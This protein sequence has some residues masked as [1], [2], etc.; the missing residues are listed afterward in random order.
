MKRLAPSVIVAA[1]VFCA[2]CTGSADDRADPSPAQTAP[3]TD[4]P[5]PTSAPTT[6]ATEV[7]PPADSDPEITT[8]DGEAAALRQPSARAEWGN[9]PF[10]V[11]AVVDDLPEVLPPPDASQT[12]FGGSDQYSVVAVDWKA[13]FSA[14]DRMWPPVIESGSAERRDELVGDLFCTVQNCGN[15]EPGG[16]GLSI[17][18]PFGLSSNGRATEFEKEFGFAIENIEAVAEASRDRTTI[19]LASGVDLGA[20]FVPAGPIM[21]L[22]VGDDYAL[23]GEEASDWRKFGEPIRAAQR[24]GVIG[25]ALSTPLI[26]EWSSGEQQALTSSPGVAAVATAL[27]EFSLF[28]FVLEV[29]GLRSRSCSP[30]LVPL[31]EVTEPFE[32]IGMGFTVID[33]QRAVVTTTAFSSESAASSMVEPTRNVWT[34]FIDPIE[35][36][37]MSDAFELI[38]VSASGTVVTAVAVATDDTDLRSAY[39]LLLQGAPVAAYC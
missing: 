13:A 39:T 22:G 3:T 16:T 19:T 11:L 30:E 32:V 6:V 29:G 33:G 34:G 7:E 8:V 5:A 4:A 31:Y 18:A 2:A 14:T 23:I 15:W 25:L 9:E 17:V 37:P 27:D 26:E 38:D 28:S 1:S 20:P 36:R 24:D 21:T 10:S 35:G 12:T